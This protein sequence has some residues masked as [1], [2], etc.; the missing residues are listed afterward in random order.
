MRDIIKVFKALSDPARIRIIKLLEKKSM[1]VCELT[2]VLNA[3][4][5]NVSRHLGILK[6]AGLVNCVKEGLWIN[7][8][9][10]K[11]KYNKNAPG[12]LKLISNMLNDEQRIVEDIKVAQ[13]IKR[14]EVC[15][16]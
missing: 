8:E 12:V 15:K 2:K 6:D 1:C 9:L 7:Y 13:R 4:Q 14:E 11:D 10:S 3:R 5:P 16:K